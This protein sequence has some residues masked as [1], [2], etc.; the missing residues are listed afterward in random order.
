[1]KAIIFNR[2]WRPSA[3]ASSGLW[4]T[5]AA[6]TA[7]LLLL[8]TANLR[9]GA[10]NGVVVGSVCGGGISPFYGYVEG[11]PANSTLAK[12]NTPIGL[13]LDSTG[14]FLFVADQANN[15]DPRG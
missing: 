14:D 15:A 7:A 9:A 4:A 13:A 10:P 11:N 6:L 1:M 5:G 3:P 8:A 12:F 2:P